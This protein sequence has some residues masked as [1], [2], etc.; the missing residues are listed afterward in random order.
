MNS[1]RRLL[2]R[3]G[4]TAGFAML[5]GG[6]LLPRAAF[7]TRPDK[8]FSA[9]EVDAALPEIGGDGASASE[10]INL[11]GPPGGLAENGAVVPIKVDTKLEN[12]ESI[13]IFAKSNFNPLVA[14][15]EFGEGAVPYVDTR[16]KMAESGDVVAVVKAG[17]KLYSTSKS[18]KVVAGGC[19]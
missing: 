12:V 4:L 11:Q 8:A 16:I 19:G 14:V 9:K 10:E 18:V 15:Y 2:A 6:G 7:A 3:A 17:G 13:S 1:R 5:A